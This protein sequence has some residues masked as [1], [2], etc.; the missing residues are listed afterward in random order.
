MYSKNIDCNVTVPPIAK[1]LA[2]IENVH[3]HSF[4]RTMATNILTKGMPIEEVQEILGHSK[5]DTTM[6]YCEINKER[7]KHHHKNICPHNRG[8]EIIM[9]KDKIILSNNYEIEI[10]SGA[11]LSDIRVISDTKYDMVSLW[12]MMTEENLKSVQVVNRDGI[13]VATY[14]DLILVSETSRET[15]DGKIETRFNLREKT[16]TEKRLDALEEGQEVQDGAIG[17]LGAAVSGLAEEGGLA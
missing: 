9:N 7:I 11:S 2:G 17:D 12:D 6:I 4:R 8:K 14:S 10:E 3:P 1:I 5:L 15:T 13:T 16:D